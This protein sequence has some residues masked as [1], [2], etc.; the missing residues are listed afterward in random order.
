MF[1]RLFTVLLFTALL[2]SA[3][4]FCS[5]ILI[6]FAVFRKE[7][8]QLQLHVVC[9]RCITRLEVEL[10]VKCVVFGYV[11]RAGGRTASITLEQRVGVTSEPEAAVEQ[12]LRVL[13]ECADPH[14][15]EEGDEDLTRVLIRDLVLVGDHGLGDADLG[16]GGHPHVLAH[17]PHHLRDLCL[18]RLRLL[19]QIS[20]GVIVKQSAIFAK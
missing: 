10:L 17:P 11:R 4:T 16:A 2:V 8:V 14:V 19:E 18:G 1:F 3:I 13:G 12:I 7:V 20:P 6:I 9:I 15:G 5:E